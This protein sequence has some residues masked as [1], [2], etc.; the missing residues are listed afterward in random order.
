MN[1]ILAN[2]LEEKRGD[3]REATVEPEGR[4]HDRD[5]FGFQNSHSEST[6]VSSREATR[7]IGVPA[8]ASLL[9]IF[10]AGRRTNS[11][12][13]TTTATASMYMAMPRIMASKGTV[14]ASKKAAFATGSERTVAT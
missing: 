8:K 4:G 7:V 1:R 13:I 11:I 10:C 9:L 14:F 6:V 3:A 5:A 2:G 12:R